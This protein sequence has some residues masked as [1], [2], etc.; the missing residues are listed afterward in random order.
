[1]PHKRQ[2]LGNKDNSTVNNHFPNILLI[3]QR[4]RNPFQNPEQHSTLFP[5]HIHI[6]KN[7]ANHLTLFRMTQTQ[8]CNNKSSSAFRANRMHRLLESKR[9]LRA[10]Q[11]ISESVGLVSFPSARSQQKNKKRQTLSQQMMQRLQNEQELDICN[12]L[13]WEPTFIDAGHSNNWPL[14]LKKEKKATTSKKTNQDQR[15]IQRVNLLCFDFALASPRLLFC[16]LHFQLQ[17]FTDLLTAFTRYNSESLK[18]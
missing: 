4:M 5:Q 13:H 12:I 3:Q 1:M 10:I 14:F 16:P 17:K 15:R 2:I 18:M 8:L 9:K 11:V 7:K 6:F